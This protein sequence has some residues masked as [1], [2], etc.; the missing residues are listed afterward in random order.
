MNISA[1][2]DRIS[3]DSVSYSFCAIA[4]LLLNLCQPFVA[5]DRMRC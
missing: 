4:E 1:A 2:G 5:Y 3:T